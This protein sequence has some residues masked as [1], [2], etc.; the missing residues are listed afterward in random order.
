MT[1]PTSPA[2]L[3]RVY[4][5][6]S[7]RAHGKPVYR[8]IVE[9]ALASGLAGAS[10]FRVALS[11]GSRGRLN[12]ERSDYQSADIPVLVE[13]VDAPEKVEALL[14]ALATT[15]GGGLATVQP[16]GLV[17]AR[18]TQAT[19][20]PHGSEPM[21]IDGDAQRV[22]VYLGSSDTWN[23][24]NLAVAIVQHCR[25]LGIAGATVTR[26]VMG[27]GHRSIVHRAHFLGLS[28]DLP[29]RIEIID[30]PERVALLLPVL[31]EMAPGALV[32]LEGVQVVG[33]NPDPTGG[34]SHEHRGPG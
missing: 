28:D 12:D 8:S 23:G 25:Q 7:D 17:R 34:P 32:V 14:A 3:L 10:V 27:F 21:P 30:R 16:V 20:Q 29:E 15:L 5:N 9:A 11:Y 1:P 4:V 24:G 6:S 31:A 13:L 22:T 18:V 19:S 2:S 33:P 26:G